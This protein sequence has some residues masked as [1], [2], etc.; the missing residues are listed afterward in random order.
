[1]RTTI[2]ETTIHDSE[3]N[4]L[5]GAKET[6]S[7]LQDNAKTTV[8]ETTIH[9]SE[10]NNLTGA[11]ETYS[12]LQDGAKTTVKETTIHDSEMNNLTGAKET[13]STLQDG[14]KTTVKETLLHDSEM[15]NL[16]GA[17][18]T[19]SALQDGVKTTVKE[20]LIHDS[21]IINIKAGNANYTKNDDEAKKTLRQTLPK[22]DTTRNI[23]TSVYK[24]Y[25][26]DPDMVVK[27]TIKETTIKGK[28]EY[29]FLGGMLEGIFGGYLSTPIELKNTQKQY[30]SDVNEY[31]IAGSLN[32]FRQPDRTYAENAEIDGTREAI[33]MAAGHTP[34]PGNRNVG[35]DAE[36]VEM[37]SRKPFE[38]MV[39][40]RENGNVG[41]TYQSSPLLIDKCSMTKLPD[42]NNAY[43]NRLDSDLLE[44][45][46]TNDFMIKL[47][48]IKTGCRV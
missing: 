14:A 32:E 2:K 4:N 19:Y 40:A 16:T 10:M 27:T 9:D 24:V 37:T 11:K 43:E 46:K 1:M 33:M 23:G 35:I 26:Y 41:I 39:P 8:K 13:Y 21:T 38:N 30:V 7:A 42:T 28:S 17:K 20:T 12:A 18:E 22:L 44:P 31:G 47:N 45:I 6:Y 3:M 25:V 15:N 5:T 34:N 36:D 29:G 48:P